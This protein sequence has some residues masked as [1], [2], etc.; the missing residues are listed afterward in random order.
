MILNDLFESHMSDLDIQYQ[1][2]KN[3]EPVAFY[4]RYKMTP[5]E[6]ASKHWSLIKSSETVHENDE[7]NDEAG[8]AHTNL[9][10]TARAVQ[11]LI[12][13]IKSRDNLPEW[14][15]EKIAKAEGMLVGVWDYLLSQKEQGIDPQVD[16]EKD[17]CYHKVKSRYKVWPS[18][19][20]SGALVQ[21]RKKGA[22]NWGNKSKK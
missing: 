22:A 17:A 14:V 7:Y 8:M 18:A 20:A 3:L 11:G 21:C 4:S 10:T 5:D 15:Q 16:E 12:D 2:Y 9:H 6:W 1:D 13:T 19:Y